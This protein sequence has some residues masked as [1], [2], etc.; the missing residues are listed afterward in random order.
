MF[1]RR[2]LR[3]RER[4]YDLALNLNWAASLCLSTTP[5]YRTLGFTSTML[6]TR[7]VGPAKNRLLKV[8]HTRIEFI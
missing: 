1:T 5:L 8:T 2:P 7:I 3:L 6:K 4:P